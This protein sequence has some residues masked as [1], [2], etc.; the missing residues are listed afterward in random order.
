M[1]YCAVKGGNVSPR[2]CTRAKHPQCFAPKRFGYCQEVER[3]V[4]QCGHLHCTERQSQN[5]SK[6]ISGRY[7]LD[8]VGNL[9][10]LG[11]RSKIQKP[12]PRTADGKVKPVRVNKWTKA[13]RVHATRKW[14]VYASMAAHERGEIS[15]RER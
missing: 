2:R 4:P 13:G 5:L 3:Y 9:L 14:D 6:L 15:H 7:T 10:D 11:K 1:R 8:S 12:M